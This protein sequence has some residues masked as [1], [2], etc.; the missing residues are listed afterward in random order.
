MIIKSDAAGVTGITHT[1]NVEKTDM[2][3]TMVVDTATSIIM[4]ITVVMQ[5]DATG[6][7]FYYD[8]FTVTTTAAETMDGE[9]DETP[10]A[11]TNGD[12]GSSDGSV[13][14]FVGPFVFFSTIASAALLLLSF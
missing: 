11:E 9:G 14:S 4:D 13:P 10:P 1:S 3:M 12:D 5:N 2:T 7:I 6:S 8:Q